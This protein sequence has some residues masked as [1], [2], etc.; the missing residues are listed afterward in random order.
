VILVVGA[1]GYL[2]GRVCQELVAQGKQV[3]AMVR[4]GDDDARLE[5]LRAAGVELV[6]GDLKDAASLE[7]ACQGMAAVISTASS[8]ISHQSGDTI[9][10]VDRDGQRHLVDA[11]KAAGVEQFVYISF[12]KNMVTEGPLTAAKRAV[13]DH[14]RASGM[15]YTILRCGFLMEIMVTPM[16]GFDFANASAVVYGTGDNPISWVSIDDVARLAVASLDAPGARNAI[17]EFGADAVTMHEAVRIFEEVSGRPFEVQHVPEE[18]LE[19]QRDAATDLVA[20]SLAALMLDYAHGDAIDSAA[21]LAT[22]P[23][24]LTSIRDYATKVLS[25]P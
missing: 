7:R 18:A 13:E 9:D 2:G 23:M 25:S 6:E 21:A 5:P 1:T 19:A 20:R 22:C 24:E 16:V 11:A 12:S 14:L 3:T 17:F 10:T 8:S 4:G 15:D